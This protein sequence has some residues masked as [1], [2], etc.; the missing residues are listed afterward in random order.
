M[1]VRQ[2]N[3]RRRT[4]EVLFRPIANSSFTEPYP[5]IDERPSPIGVADTKQIDEGD[6][7]FLS[8]RR[9]GLGRN[10]LIF[11]NIDAVHGTL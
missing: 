10:H 11:G 2:E 9:N 7:K 8:S 1:P 4:V 6:A 5:G 3:R